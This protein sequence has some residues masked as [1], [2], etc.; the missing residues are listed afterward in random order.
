MLLL[1]I[2]DDMMVRLD[3]SDRWHDKVTMFI[4]VVL[5]IGMGV[6]GIIVAGAVV[7]WLFLSAPVVFGSA[8][9]GVLILAVALSI[10]DS[11]RRVRRKREEEENDVWW[12]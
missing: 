9:A 8:V 11:V 7:G 4:L 10:R 6:S 5:F 3:R 12:W 2:W 1:D